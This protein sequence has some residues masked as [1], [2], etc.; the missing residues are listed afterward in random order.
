MKSLINSW[1]IILD[2]QSIAI[3][4]AK[5]ISSTTDCLKRAIAKFN[6]QPRDKFEGQSYQL[7]QSLQWSDA[8]DLEGLTAVELG[9][10]PGSTI[11]RNLLNKGIRA[12]HMKKRAEEEVNM[13][14]D[15]MKNAAQFYTTE[16]TRLRYHIDEL[17]GVAKTRYTNGCLNILYHRLFQCE[18]TLNL[19]AQRF[20]SYFSFTYPTCSVI[21][22]L[23]G[24]D[25][26]YR[27]DTSLDISTTNVH[28]SSPD[29]ESDFDDD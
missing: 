15:D 12:Y 21:E 14:V 1:F 7:P 26:M 22:S 2:G 19:Y 6:S 24:N 27:F 9:A 23:Y 18:C 16:H 28:D 8:V 29:P 13:A 25:F 3:R 5:R 4:L 20:S 17:R 11:D 10:L